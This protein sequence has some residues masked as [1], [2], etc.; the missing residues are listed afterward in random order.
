MRFKLNKQ[1]LMTFFVLSALSY[2]WTK[3]DPVENEVRR[4]EMDIPSLYLA[5]GMFFSAEQNKQLAELLTESARLQKQNQRSIQSFVRQYQKETDLLID[6]MI[7]G[8]KGPSQKP[9]VNYP[10][11]MNLRKVRGEWH[12]LI[13]QNQRNL[14]GLAQKTL[15]LFT[16]AQRDIL[17]RFVPCFIPPGDFRNPERVGQADGDTSLGEN[18]LAKLRGAPE[19]KLDAAIERAL[20]RLVPYIMKE[21]HTDLT[22]PQIDELRA[23]LFPS[24]LKLTKQIRSMSDSDFELEKKNLAKEFLC[25]QTAES[26]KQDR[27]DEIEKIKRYLLN[28]GIASVIARRAGKPAAAADISPAPMADDIKEKN[29]MFQSA[30]LINNLQ[31][32]AEQARQLLPCVQKAVKARA[33]IDLEAETVFPQAFKA[34]TALEDELENQQISQKTEQEAG[35]YHHQLKMLYEE[36][37]SKTILDCE[38]EMDL[39][40]SADQVAMLIGRQSGKK[41]ERL[42]SVQIPENVSAV[43]SRA[44]G[45]FDAMDKMSDTKFAA[46][47]HDLCANFVES[48]IA[49]GA[50]DGNDIDK[51]S[52]IK[53][54][55]QVLSNARRMRRAEYVKS[56]EDL[57][58]KICPRRNKP[59][60]D[61][62]S[63]KRSQGD[64]LEVVNQSSQLLLSQ[65]GLTLL[66]KKI[67]AGN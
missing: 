24:L 44:R 64:Q 65:T 62:F 8:R 37:L 7:S 34:Y 9:A 67:K 63:W 3:A 23:G 11:N 42:Q 38:T 46:N 52:E 40:L 41:Y 29:R 56:R 66:E 32:T 48:C 21:K 27:S 6:Q 60:P 49:S 28:P 50:I 16:P 17:D 45:V 51:D 30:A 58:A 35:K 57:I 33:E 47:C 22:K 20:D 10:Q 4:L 1:M 15:A 25:L 53:R 36:K 61:V 2:S 26:A 5:N 55:E 43:R 18:M 31:L 13:N 39:L 59:R 14:D 19:V 54:A 12:K